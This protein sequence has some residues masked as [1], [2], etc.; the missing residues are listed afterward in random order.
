VDLR[1][2]LTCLPTQTMQGPGAAVW[3]EDWQVVHGEATR[4]PNFFDEHRH[5]D[6][7]METQRLLRERLGRYCSYSRAVSFANQGR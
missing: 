4:E 2:L 6:P 1:G 7:V 5:E 3:F